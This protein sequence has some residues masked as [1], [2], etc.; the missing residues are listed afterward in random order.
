MDVPGVSVPQ[1]ATTLV[2]HVLSAHNGKPLTDAKL[3][4]ILSLRCGEEDEL[5]KDVCDD[6]LLIQCLEKDEIE[7]LQDHQKGVRRR[8]EDR[9]AFSE[10]VRSGDAGVSA[11][12]E[13]NFKVGKMIQKPFD[14]NMAK[15]FLPPGCTIFHYVP[16]NRVMGF[17]GPTGAPSHGCSLAFSLDTAIRVVLDFLWRAHKDRNPGITVPYEFPANWNLPGSSS[18]SSA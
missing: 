1:T 8:N 5:F 7:A 16:T 14:L 3:H 15:T 12:K 13:S 18:S 11:P 17:Y 10:A 2:Q 4:Q 9:R 6:D